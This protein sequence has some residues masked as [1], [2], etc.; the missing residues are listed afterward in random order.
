MGLC[1]NRTRPSIPLAA[2]IIYMSTAKPQSRCIQLQASSTSPELIRLISVNWLNGN[3][4]VNQLVTIPIRTRHMRR[5][6][7]VLAPSPLQLSIVLMPNA[8]LRWKCRH[9]PVAPATVHRRH[10]PAVVLHHLAAVVAAAVHRHRWM[11]PVRAAHHPNRALA[12]NHRYRVPVVHHRQ[13]V[14]VRNHRS[15]AQAIA[16]SQPRK[17]TVHKALAVRPVLLVPVHPALR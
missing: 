1:F 9:R 17:W 12:V 16:V 10:H 13:I 4:I 5:S 2:V 3:Q 7:R 6:E 11:I 8:R 14:Q 15:S